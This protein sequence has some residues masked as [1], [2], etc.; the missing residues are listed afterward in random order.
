MNRKSKTQLRQRQVDSAAVS[1][2][3]PRAAVEEGSQDT[4]RSL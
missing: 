3:D 2:E 4:I 1:L